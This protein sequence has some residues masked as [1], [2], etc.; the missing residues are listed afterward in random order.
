MEAFTSLNVTVLDVNDNAPDF[1]FDSYPSDG[2]LFAENQPAHTP[3]FKANAI[4]KDI[5]ENGKVHSF[6][7]IRTIL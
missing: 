4:D 5:G 2:F 1:Q 6:F 3:V 7:Y